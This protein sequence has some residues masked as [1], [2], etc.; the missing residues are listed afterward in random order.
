VALDRGAIS[1]DSEH[2]ILV[3]QDVHGGPQVE[4]L[5]FEFSGR[6]L[7]RPVRPNPLL[8]ERFLSWHRREVFRHPARGF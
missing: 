2:R 8:A 3:S 1:I 5:L 4:K 7:S 6:S